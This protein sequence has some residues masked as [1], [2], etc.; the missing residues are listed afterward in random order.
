MTEGF[1]RRQ[2]YNNPKAKVAYYRSSDDKQ[3]KGE[4]ALWKFTLDPVEQKVLRIHESFY[5]AF[6]GKME[7]KSAKIW[8]QYLMILCEREH[9]IRDDLKSIKVYGWDIQQRKMRS[10]GIDIDT[11]KNQAIAQF[12]ILDNMLAGVDLQ[13]LAM[14][15]SGRILIFSLISGQILRNF[16]DT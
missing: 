11:Y 3:Q 16:S 6:T 8:R 13:L 2:V 5:N 9:P 7:A 1:L 12:Q 4:V 15:S 10:I 14:V